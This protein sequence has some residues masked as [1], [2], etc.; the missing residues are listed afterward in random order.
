MGAVDAAGLL[1]VASLID[2]GRMRDGLLCAGAVL[3]QLLS[4]LY[5]AM[6]LV[7]ALTWSAPSR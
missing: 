1:G 4:S 6:F 7:I 2:T 3:L 5:Y